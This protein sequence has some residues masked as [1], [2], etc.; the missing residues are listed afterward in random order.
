MVRRKIRR[1]FGNVLV[2]I[3]FVE[4][5]NFSK[6]DLGFADPDPVA[7]FEGV[8]EMRLRIYENAIDAADQL[9]ILLKTIE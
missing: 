2:N 3:L 4:G 5:L 8:F 6:L 7:F 9:S 1:L